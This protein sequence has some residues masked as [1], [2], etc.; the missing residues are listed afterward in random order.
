MLAHEFG[1]EVCHVGYEDS[2]DKAFVWKDEM[3]VRECADLLISV[4]S[5]NANNTIVQNNFDET[6]LQSECAMKELLASRQRILY[7]KGNTYPRWPSR[8]K[9]GMNIFDGV[10]K[11]SQA[12]AEILPWDV[13]NPQAI[14]VH[15]RQG[16]NELD[17]RDGLDEETL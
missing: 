10:F 8:E 5:S 3:H 16:D 2:F 15:L 9:D 11:P 13:G 14:V 4:R 6:A 17:N 1:R 7:Y 12:L